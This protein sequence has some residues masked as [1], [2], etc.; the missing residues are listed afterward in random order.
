MFVVLPRP[1]VAGLDLTLPLHTFGSTFAVGDRD[2][3]TTH[4]VAPGT[5]VRL[6]VVNT[7]SAPHRLM[8][9]GTPFRVAAVDGTDLNEPAEV[10]RVAVRLAA[11]GR[12]DLALVMGPEPVTLRIDDH[13]AA[14]R[15]IPPGTATSAVAGDGDTWPTLDLTRYGT[16]G[17]VPFDARSRF[18]RRYTMVL[19]RGLSLVDRSPTFAFTVNGRGFPHVTVQRVRTGDLVHLTV[20]NRSRDT[21]PIHVHGHHVLALTY[22]GRQFL[23]SPLWMDTFDVQPGEVWEVALRADNPGVWMNHCHNLRHAAGGMAV[24]LAYDGYTAPNHHAHSA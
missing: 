14:V 9:D 2:E 4:S 16:P 11:G 17:A 18:D 12:A 22:N 19:D 3:P 5:A 20:V 1:G 6:R 23:G 7:D 13:A 21:H 8:L 24:H 10:R 15:L